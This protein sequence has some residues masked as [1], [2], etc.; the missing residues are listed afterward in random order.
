M[1][2]LFAFRVEDLDHVAVKTDRNV[3]FGVVTHGC[4]ST[5]S[6]ATAHG[7]ALFGHFTRLI[8]ASVWRG[9]KSAGR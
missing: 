1:A 9:T 6:S 2:L 7:G 8:I 5:T 4:T 3:H